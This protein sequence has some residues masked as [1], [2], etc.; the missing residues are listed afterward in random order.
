MCV[1]T[2]IHVNDVHVCKFPQMFQLVLMV[3]LNFVCKINYHNCVV[4][5]NVLIGRVHNNCNNFYLLCYS[6]DCLLNGFLV[7]YLALLL[8]LIVIIMLTFS[9]ESFSG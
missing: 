1:T 8:H 6:E 7:H 3:E 5:A 9:H 2:F 4:T